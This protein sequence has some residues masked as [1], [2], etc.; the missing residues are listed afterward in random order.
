MDQ[1]LNER[2]QN[3]RDIAGTSHPKV[4]SVKREKS[5]FTGGVSMKSNF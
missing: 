5:I 4:M 3:T 2:S 1:S